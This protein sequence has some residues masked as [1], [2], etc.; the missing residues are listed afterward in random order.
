MRPGVPPRSVL[1]LGPL[2]P[3][4]GLVGCLLVAG[5][6]HRQRTAPNPSSSGSAHRASPPHHAWLAQGTASFYG[7]GLWGNKTASGERLRKQDLTA[8]S[9]TLRFGTCLDVLNLDNGKRVRVRVNDRG[10]YAG[11]RLIDVSYA[12]GRALG[13]LEKGLAHVRLFLCGKAPD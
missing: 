4:L 12:A 3:L 6:A 11:H 9:R 7:P 8:A 13:M 1:R 10:P 2:A 5:C